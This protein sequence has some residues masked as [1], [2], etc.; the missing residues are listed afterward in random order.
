MH[1]TV[2]RGGG[3]ERVPWRNGSGTSRTILTRLGRDGGLLWQIGIAD[4]TGDAPFSDYRGYDRIFT[5][6]AGT[7]ALAFDGG[8]LEACDLLVPRRFAGE[9][10]VQCHVAAPGQAFN[11]ISLRD[12]L[13]AELR[14]VALEAGDPIEAPDAPEVL[15]H[16]LAGELAAAG[17]LLLPGDSLL[18]PGPAEPGSASA[19][20]TAIVVAL[21][22][23][24]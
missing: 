20:S 7:I 12:R 23:I 14:V 2:I 16:C 4:L 5:P 18:G 8:P 9:T 1:W 11:V 3:L 22:A 17:D 24:A 21:R 19:D 6:L 13:A 10:P 15:I